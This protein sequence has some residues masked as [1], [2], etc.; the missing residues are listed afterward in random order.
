MLSFS[1]M[2]DGKNPYESISSNSRNAIIRH[3]VVYYPRVDSTMNIARREARQGVPEGTAII[4]G[5]QTGGRGRSNRRWLTPPGNIAMSVILYPDIA[6]L[7]YL[8]MI[9]SLAVVQGIKNVT[10]LSADIKWPNDILIGGK[11]VGGILI[12]NE[13]SGGNAARAII[14]IGI[15]IDI[16]ESAVRGS[17]VPATSLEKE[18]RQA[19]EKVDVVK[20]VLGEMDRLYSKLPDA[21]EIFTEW[22]RKLVTLGKRVVVTSGDEIFEGTADSVEP[23][24][25]LVV[26]LGDGTSTQVVAGDVTLRHNDQK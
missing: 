20:R 23:G 22:Q 15:N 11:K 21:G 18:S 14:G 10:G 13:I 19:V 9:A 26:K 5:E 17:A 3:N 24:G 16:E 1:M 8:V 6:C 7:P 25:A 2:S 4:A 12:E